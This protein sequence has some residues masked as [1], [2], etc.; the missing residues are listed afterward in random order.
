MRVRKEGKKEGREGGNGKRNHETSPAEPSP[1][2]HPCST[3]SPSHCTAPE[4]ASA[5][6]TVQLDDDHRYREEPSVEGH[7]MTCHSEPARVDP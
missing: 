2:L 3:I 4:D 5:I 7:L 6:R 1:A